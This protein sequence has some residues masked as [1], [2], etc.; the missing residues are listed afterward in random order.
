MIFWKD[1]KYFNQHCSTL[2]LMT[3]G[4]EN[5]SVVWAV[6]CISCNHGLYPLS[7]QQNLPFP[8]SCDNKKCLQTLKTCP[9]G[10]KFTHGW[11]PLIIQYLEHNK[12]LKSQKRV[13]VVFNIGKNDN[14]RLVAQ[15]GKNLP[16]KQ[17]PGFNPWF[18]K[19]SWRKEWLPTL[20]SLLGELHGQRRLE[21]CDEVRKESNTTEQLTCTPTHTQREVDPLTNL[22]KPKT[23]NYRKTHSS[24]KLMD[25]SNEI[26]V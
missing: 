5:S 24:S 13:I 4:P 7:C 8:Y 26:S 22:N 3:S 1:R 11:E 20:V 17:V 18:W 14:W 19:I 15:T 21:G 12:N 10:G 23:L 16:A 6:L 25:C 9:S 2:A